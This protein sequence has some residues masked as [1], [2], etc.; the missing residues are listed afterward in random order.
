VIF[1]V[2]TWIYTVDQVFGHCE[3]TYGEKI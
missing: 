3:Y 1:Y 2:I